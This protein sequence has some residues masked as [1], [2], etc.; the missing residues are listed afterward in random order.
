MIIKKFKGFKI[1]FFFYQKK[2]ITSIEHNYFSI[3]KRFLY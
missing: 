3:E 1:F 2:I